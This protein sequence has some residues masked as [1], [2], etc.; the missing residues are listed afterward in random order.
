M[1]PY[2]QDTFSTLFSEQDLLYFITH[3]LPRWVSRSALTPH[4][5]MT[6]WFEFGRDA[7]RAA[8]V[9]FTCKHASE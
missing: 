7:A 6:D 8:P 1:S 3:D 4:P 5:A 2:A 9:E